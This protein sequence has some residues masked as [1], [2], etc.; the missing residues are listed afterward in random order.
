MWHG[1]TCFTVK[2]KSATVV[3]DPFEGAGYDKAK[4]KGHII[5]S[6]KIAEGVE[7]VAVD[8]E[9]KVFDYPGEYERMGVAL[10]GIQTEEGGTIFVFDLDGI[11]VCHL[12][13]MSKVPSSKIIE[14]IGGVDIVL[15]PVGGKEVLDAKKAHEVIEEIEPRVVVPMYYKTENEKA[16][17]N[18]VDPFLKEVGAQNSPIDKYSIDSKAK[19][20]QDHEEYVVLNVDV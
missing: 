9:P 18:P 2:G 11:R 20:P 15:V 1:R 5:T 17:L 19:L 14:S 7:M 16:D 8:G 6:S 4:L 3:T 13:A 10:R 12:G